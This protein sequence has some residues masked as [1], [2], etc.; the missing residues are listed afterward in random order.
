[1][2]KVGKKVAY[3]VCPVMNYLTAW[4]FVKSLRERLEVKDDA[5]IVFVMDGEKAWLDPI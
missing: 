5:T 1:M 3:E 4:K 2:S